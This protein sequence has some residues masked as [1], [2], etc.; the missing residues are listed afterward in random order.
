MPMY[1]ARPPSMRIE[2]LNLFTLAHGA[3]SGR[4]RDGQTAAAFGVAVSSKL[5]ESLADERLLHGRWAQDLFRAVLISL[6]AITLIKDEDV[7]ELHHDA[8]KPLRLPDFRVVAKTGEQLLV[9]VKN[10]GPKGLLKAQKIRA[11][12]VAELQEYARLTAG[13]LV[14]AHYCSAVNKWTV[15]DAERLARRGKY[16]ELTLK[17]A[18]RANELGL[19]GDVMLMTASTITIMLLEEGVEGAPV[20]PDLAGWPLPFA[21][22]SVGF[23]CDGKLVTDP[24]EYELVKAVTLYGG[25]TLADVKTIV[26]DD[27]RIIGMVL[28]AGSP[29]GPELP[30]TSSFLSSIFT[31][32]YIAATTDIIDGSVQRMRYEPDPTLTRLTRVAAAY[33]PGRAMP[34]AVHTQYPT[35]PSP[36]NQPH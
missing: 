36:E 13:R 31:S 3:E 32:R 24:E 19:L 28:T 20:D 23:G 35:A 22:G 18:F 1:R 4:L 21:L 11:D 15:V 14:F 30:N 10:V 33:G 16:F 17:D 25:L 9:E 2:A 6:D 29:A 26:D 8:D 12:A 27:E 5:A 34:V 7:G